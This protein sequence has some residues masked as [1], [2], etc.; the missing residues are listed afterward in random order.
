MRSRH[1]LVT[2]FVDKFIFNLKKRRGK[3]LAEVPVHWT[4]GGESL[5]RENGTKII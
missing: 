2:A 5:G 3:A 4:M 1:Y